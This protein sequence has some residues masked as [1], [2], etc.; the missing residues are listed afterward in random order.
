MLTSIFEHFELK[1]IC[2]ASIVLLTILPK[3]AGFI[4]LGGCEGPVAVD[5]SVCTG[6]PSL[7]PHCLHRK[8]GSNH[9]PHMPL[10]IRKVIV[11]TCPL[12][13][14]HVLIIS[15]LLSALFILLWSVSDCV[16]TASV[17]HERPGAELGSLHRR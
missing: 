4:L 17:Q 11:F 16:S 8:D 7:W 12:T 2:L 3:S 5:I 1:Y 15:H 13:A 9:F 10:G 14:F 6:L